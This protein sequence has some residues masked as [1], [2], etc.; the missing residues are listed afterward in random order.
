MGFFGS[1]DKNQ[2][3]SNAETGVSDSGLLIGAGS[4]GARDDG[5]VIQG[6][7]QSAIKIGNTDISNQ[8]NTGT[9]TYGLRGEDLIAGLSDVTGQ[10][11]DIVGKQ[12][13]A[14]TSQI[15]AT[16]AGLS[17]LALSK[18]TEGKSGTDNTVLY[19]VAGVLA[20]IAFIF[21]RK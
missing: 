4:G 8:G 6:G 2:T 14:A 1:G 18:Q 15:N 12:T 17:D 5:T 7:Y 16:L 13:D 11:G 10:I 20:L 19:V 9:I 3:T 21:W